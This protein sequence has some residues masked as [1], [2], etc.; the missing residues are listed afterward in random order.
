M[1]RSHEN[2]IIQLIL[3]NRTLR[4]QIISLDNLSK[5]TVDLKESL[6]FT[7]EKTEGNFNRLNEK[8][9]RLK[10]KLGKILG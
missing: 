6:E 3:G 2:S 5:E 4:N 9:S 7:Q 10:G 1:F 8:I